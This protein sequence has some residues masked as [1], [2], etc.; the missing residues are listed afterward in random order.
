MQT[1]CKLE[2]G[3]GQ[4]SG[5]FANVVFECPL[6]DNMQVKYLKILNDE[7][8][9]YLRQN[10]NNYKNNSGCFSSSLFCYCAYCRVLLKR[11]IFH[12]K[13][14]ECCQYQTHKIVEMENFH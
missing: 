2:G 5:K 9:I 6:S 10:K 8:I 1:T 13:N 12:R 14:T 4:K 7:F 11:M 3:G